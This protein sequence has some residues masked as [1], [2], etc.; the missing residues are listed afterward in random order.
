MS[1]AAGT[2]HVVF[3]GEIYNFP[4]VRRE[5]EA[6]GYKFRSASDT[7]VIIHGYA[8]WGR[9]CVSRFNGMF[10]FALWDHRNQELLLARDRIGIKPIYY[11]IMDGPDRNLA[12]ASELKALLECPNVDRTLNVQALYQFMGFEFVPSPRTI[13]ENI[14]RLAPGCCLTWKRGLEPGVERYWR[15]R[16]RTVHRSREEHE[17]K[18]R[19]LLRQ[20]VQRQL[21]ADV[22][23]GVFLSGGL[24]SSAIVSMMSQL[25]VEPLDSFSLHYEDATYSELDYANYVARQFKTRHH[26]VK[27]DPVTPDLIDTCCW[28]MD[29]PMADLSAM[30][31][32]LLCKQVREHVTVCLSGEGGDELL[33]GY[34]RFKASKMHRRYAMIPSAIR[35]RLIGRFVMGLSDRPQKKGLSNVLKRRLDCSRTMP[36]QRS[37]STRSLPYDNYWKGRIAK[38]R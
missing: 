21:I 10:A 7:E 32:Y 24:D 36:G 28:H 29:E 34:D 8:E 26:V 23:L 19:E 18:L 3:N 15:L 14:Y 16:V 35:K 9:D 12:F 11:T 13:F 5:L 38:T 4:D 2:I 37:T 6:K 33:C 20:S 30:P 1:N 22:P 31:F 25:G 17:Q 27:I